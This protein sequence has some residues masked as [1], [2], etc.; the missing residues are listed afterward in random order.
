VSFNPNKIIGF[1]FMDPS[2]PNSTL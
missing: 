2:D 1:E